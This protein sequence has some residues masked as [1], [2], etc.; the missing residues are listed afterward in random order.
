MN[1]WLRNIQKYVDILVSLTLVIEKI[2][3]IL[4][5]INKWL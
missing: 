1:G 4:E 2:S 3:V 5:S